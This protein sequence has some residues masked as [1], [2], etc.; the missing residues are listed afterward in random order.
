[1]TLSSIDYEELYQD[2]MTP[3]QFN[4]LDFLGVE[5]RGR[6]V[7]LID[8]DIRTK[9]TQLARY[10]I[11]ITALNNPDELANVKALLDYCIEQLPPSLLEEVEIPNERL[12]HFDPITGVNHIVIG[13][14][15]KK[16]KWWKIALAAAVVA[17][18][19]TVVVLSGGAG[20][21]VAQA[22][23][24]S[25]AATTG[26][27]ATPTPNR[28]RDEPDPK[29][30]PAVSSN[31]PPPKPDSISKPFLPPVDLSDLRPNPF[32]LPPI[33]PPPGNFQPPP[34]TIP[35][36]SGKNLPTFNDYLKNSHPV[37][38]A[39]P[40]PI[41]PPISSPPSHPRIIEIP[42]KT[43]ARGAI[44]GINGV[45]NNL[46][47]ATANAQYLAKLAGGHKIEWIHNKTNT[48]VVDLIESTMVNYKG[49]S[50][51]AKDLLEQ[52]TA[53]HE[54]HRNDPGAKFFQFC[55]SQGAIHVKNALLQ[56]PQ[57]IRDRLIVLAIAPAAV[58][59]KKLCFDSFNYASKRDP[60]P[61][62]EA[63]FKYDPDAPYEERI[64]APS[65]KELEELIWVEPQP[66]AKGIDHGA[67]SATYVQH[68]AQRLENF[69]N[70]YN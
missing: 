45:G 14:E 47:Q 34:I 52:W 27:A 63:A 16:R 8:Q 21:P 36:T 1:M 55:H 25:A 62:M 58:I 28:R 23:I 15:R 31:P 5:W 10:A 53:F 3:D 37:T 11:E 38:F 61:L 22:A 26:A 44:G 65:R 39:P 68:I 48:I 66:N 46:E 54:K 4:L 69:I 49:Y 18:A 57:E 56:A 30:R 7:K 13:A 70:K 33:Q 59:P 43:L 19:V 17:A 35:P 42:G 60:I 32:P 29:N 6:N 51:P 41:P 67:D 12:C 20:A 40:A 50:A 9:I 2:S 24:A 64:N